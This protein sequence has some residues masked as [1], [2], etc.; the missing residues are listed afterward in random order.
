MV[1][2][3]QCHQAYAPHPSNVKGY[4]T[5]P[6]S[7]SLLPDSATKNKSIDDEELHFLSDTTYHHQRSRRPTCQM[8]NA[9][10]VAGE[11]ADRGPLFNIPVVADVEAKQG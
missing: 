3:G 1:Q 6:A 4:S 10:A 8:C 9:L 5:L 11:N 7:F 2:Q